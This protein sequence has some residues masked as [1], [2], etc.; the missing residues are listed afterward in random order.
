MQLADQYPG[1]PGVLVSLLM[2]RVI[3]EPG[4]ALYL[5]AGNLH[6]HLMGT[7][8]EI[9]T[10]SDNVLQGGLTTKHVDIP[11]LG[12]VVHFRPVTVD[13]LDGIPDASGVR[14]YP[15]PTAQFSLSRLDL[16]GSARW[17]W[18]DG[19]QVLLVV[20][21]SV[22]ARDGAGSSVAVPQGGSLWIPPGYPGLSVSGHGQ[23]SGRPT[24]YG[25]SPRSRRS[26]I[27]VA[28][29]DRLTHCA[30]DDPRSRFISS[31]LR[32]SYVLYVVDFD[33]DG[34]AKGVVGADI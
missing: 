12:R 20:Q 16:S 13:V 25:A 18:H 7:G 22:A 10:N 1:D 23:V 33:H 14:L 17:L 11:E 5:P 3:L 30:D 8:V 31:V 27:N 15:V 9:M 26:I 24:V 4:Q 32:R 19:P 21:G 34:T 2:N 6:A 28:H 29:R